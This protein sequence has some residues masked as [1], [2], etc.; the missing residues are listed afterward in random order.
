MPTTQSW[1]SS[2]PQYANNLLFGNLYRLRFKI[3]GYEAVWDDLVNVDQQKWTVRHL[4]IDINER[5]KLDIEKAELFDKNIPKL[6]SIRSIQF[7]FNHYTPQEGHLKVFLLSRLNSLQLTKLS[8]CFVCCQGLEFYSMTTVADFIMSQNALE[9][10]SIWNNR[11]SFQKDQL[12]VLGRA[13]GKA[14]QLKRLNLHFINC[15]DVTETSIKN[16]IYVMDI[17]LPLETVMI[18]LKGCEK[19]G[20]KVTED[21]K[22]IIR[23]KGF[24]SLKKVQVIIKAHD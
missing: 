13:L 5:C 3:E 1:I 17:I 8:L 16:L 21:F 11:I 15:P 6:L 20:L 14:K 2:P 9:S 19:I 7:D 24:P 22:S 10:L 4:K 23:N 18:S 12:Q